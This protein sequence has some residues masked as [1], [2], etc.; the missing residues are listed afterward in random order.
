ME[1]D[2]NWE[3]FIKIYRKWW[4]LIE[5]KGNRY[6][7]DTEKEENVIKMNENEWRQMY[8]IWWE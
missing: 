7:N 3:K 1:I 6:E 4:K 2:G 5:N 8:H